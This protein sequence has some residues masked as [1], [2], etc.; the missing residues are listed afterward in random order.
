M[1]I[2]ISWGRTKIKYEKT[3]VNLGDDVTLMM[4][5]ISCREKHRS[6]TTEILKEVF[7]IESLHREDYSKR[8]LTALPSAA[9]IGLGYV[10]L[11]RVEHFLV[12]HV[13]GDFEPLWDL[14]VEFCDYL[15]VEDSPDE[16]NAFRQLQEIKSKRLTS[17]QLKDKS[18]VIWE[19][20]HYE[21]N[22]EV[23]D[24]EDFSYYSIQSAIGT[25]LYN[26][27]ASDIL[28]E[29]VRWKRN[30]KESLRKSLNQISLPGVCNVKCSVRFVEQAVRQV[31]EFATV[32]EKAFVL[33]KNLSQQ[34]Q[35]EEKKAQFRNDE[36]K[37]IM[38]DRKIKEL[39]AL[40]QKMVP[41][42]L[43]HPLI[44]LLKKILEK[45]DPN[46]RVLGTFQL[47]KTLAKQCDAL[48]PSLR[49]SIEQLSAQLAESLLKTS[50]ETGNQ[51]IQ[52]ELHEAKKKYNETVVSTEHIWR[53]M[54]HI[55]A[56]NHS[57]YQSYTCLAAQHLIDGMCIELLDGDSNKINIPWIEAV[58][59]E[60]DKRLKKNG[61]SPR[62]LVLSIMGMQSSG[63]ST[64]L[65][66]M[67][68]IQMKTSVGQCT[69]GI[70][71]Q[72]I[73]TVDRKDYDYILL[74][75]TEGTRAPEY[76][77]LPGSEKRDNQMATV[78]ILLADATIIVNS[79]ENDAA[80]KEI[81]PIVLLAYQG[82]ELAE[83]M[84]GQMSSML[85][86]VYNR[87]DTREKDKLSNILQ[88]LGASLHEAFK[89]AYELSGTSSESPGGAATNS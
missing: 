43:N 14:I 2:Q 18:V 13:T 52:K 11:S 24:N 22:D 44:L 73:P 46:I 80:I 74:L 34:A 6:Q 25:Q 12:L 72:L 79:G 28:I 88:V 62:I 49:M 48:L 86:F 45:P 78:S 69:R 50:N 83:E 23:I 19:P 1:E 70:N 59:K 63:K 66:I 75:D 57:K 30:S 55:Y 10:S 17:K 58:L 60:T 41:G 87:I 5:V 33:Q 89:S 16:K 38:L 54:S 40:R 64:L 47:E 29:E 71:M 9:E 51:D 76:W 39:M 31:T 37:I 65:N 61:S 42:V 7:K 4:A 27:L 85:F 67:F 77:G 35:L 15:I 26:C 84:G 36:E 56:S 68:G 21:L 82:S 20:S 32:R 53:E 8:N 81:L 3:G